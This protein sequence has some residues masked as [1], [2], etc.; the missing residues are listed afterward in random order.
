M[1]VSYSLHLSGEDSDSNSLQDTEDLNDFLTQCIPK[2]SEELVD[3]ESLLDPACFDDLN[4][5][6]IDNSDDKAYLD[7]DGAVAKVASLSLNDDNRSVFNW[8]PEST[9]K[10]CLRELIACILQCEDVNSLLHSVQNIIP[11]QDDY[12][13]SLLHIAVSSQNVNLKIMRHLLS[14]LSEDVVNLKNKQKETALHL[15]VKQNKERVLKLLLEKGGDLSIPNQDGNN[16]LHIAAKSDFVMCME[17]LLRTTKCSY[18]H[19]LNAHNYEGVSPLHF[20]VMN[21]SLKCMDLLLQAGAYVNIIEKKGGQTPLHMAV[22]TQISVIQRLLKEPE[23]DVN[24]E[25]FRGITP[26]QLAYIKVNGVQDEG[27]M[28]RINKY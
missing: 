4:I 7:I 2:I 18:F 10:K 6:S 13:N 14:V 1:Q 26:L 23:I 27:N 22:E 8:K 17:E 12:G 3:A 28:D 9:H 11:Q 16:C 24:A 20:A 5:A 15:A 25:D 19:A 21:K